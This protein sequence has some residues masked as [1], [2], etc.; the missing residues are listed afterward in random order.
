MEVVEL[1]ILLKQV[2]QTLEG[3][4]LCYRSASRP[5]DMEETVLAVVLGDLEACSDGMPWMPQLELTGRYEIW[6]F[7]CRRTRIGC[8]QVSIPSS[9]MLFET[10]H[11]FHLYLL[12]VEG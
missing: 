3:G 5:L 2:S 8:F 10:M 12:A 9:G 7:H 11:H 4:N 1:N 6:I